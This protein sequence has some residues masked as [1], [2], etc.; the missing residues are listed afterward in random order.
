MSKYSQLAIGLNNLK[1]NSPLSVA[2]TYS[3]LKMPEVSRDIESALG[4]EYRY[5]S[6]AQEETDFL[7]GSRAMVIDKDK[8]PQWTHKSLSEVKTSEVTALLMPLNN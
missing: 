2:F 4:I 7:E 3:M 6:R 5:T 1:R 8:T